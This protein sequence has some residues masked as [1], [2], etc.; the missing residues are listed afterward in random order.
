MSK[1]IKNLKVYNTLKKNVLGFVVGG[2]VAGG[3]TAVCANTIYESSTIMTNDNDN[4]KNVLD[5]LYNK[6]YTESSFVDYLGEGTSFDL[7]S[8]EGYKNFTT[9]NFIV[10]SKVLSGAAT[11]TASSPVYAWG[12]GWVST[13]GSCTA[14]ISAKITDI[15]Y[16]N[17]TGILTISSTNCTPFV[18]LVLG[19]IE[20]NN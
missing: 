19:E 15:Q 10:G 20:K 17:E 14:S 13:S 1:D 16:N 11:C 8:Y 7:A 12:A 4:V 18:Y 5:N 3:V 2:I 6:F 9:D